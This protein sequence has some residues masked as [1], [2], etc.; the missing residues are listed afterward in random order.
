MERGSVIEITMPEGYVCSTVAYAP[1][2]DPEIAII[3]IVDEPTKGTL[4]GSTVAA[5]YV[6]A[7]LAKIL[8]YLGYEP[9]YEG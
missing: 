4:Y 8:P 7:A 3:I 5:P 2:D 9:N 1:A 6:S